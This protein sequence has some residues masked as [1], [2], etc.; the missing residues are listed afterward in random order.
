MP[1]SNL[2]KLIKLSTPFVNPHYK[3]VVGIL[4]LESRIMTDL[5]IHLSQF[6]ITYQQFNI[7]RI[8]KGQYPCG[9]QLSLLKDRM[10]HKQSD[11]SRLVNR[12]VQQ[13]LVEKNED[14][15]SKRKLSIL[16]SPA[17][18]KLI[19]SIAVGDIHF[20]SVVA[21]LTNTEVEKLNEL[22]DKILDGQL[23]K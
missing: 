6:K 23:P 22:F 8:L 20:K 2:E 7:L 10:L 16:L 15:K 17:G 4:Y 12:L 9:V 13:G 11:V 5:D 18:I 1:V 19:D 3:A 21:A 14:D